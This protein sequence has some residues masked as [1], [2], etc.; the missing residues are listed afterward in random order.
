MTQRAVVFDIGGVLEITPSI[1]TIA[2]W[3]PK[4]GLRPGEMAERAGDI[5]ADGA[6]GAITLDQVHRLLADRLTA[7]AAQVAAFLNDVWVEYLGTPNTELIDY[8]RSLRSRCR[9]GIISNSFVG[10]RER[11]Q[12][13]YGFADLT[14]CLV[15]SHEVGMSKPDPRIYLLACERLGVPPKRTLFLDDVPAAVEG[16][17]AVGIH[18]VRFES[19]T[20]AIAAIEDWLGA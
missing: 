5:W 6:V 9:T 8:L 4:F 14:D 15:Y 11:E 12:E 16:A 13:R 10:A 3:E 1:G 7:D 17:R 20:Q 2:R 18:G 19:N